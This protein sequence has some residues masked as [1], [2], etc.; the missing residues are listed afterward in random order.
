MSFGNAVKGAV[1]GGAVGA[2]YGVVPA[3]FTFGLSIPVCATANALR[4]GYN[5]AFETDANTPSASRQ[6]SP[7]G[8]SQTPTR[9]RS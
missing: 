3:L 1:Y 4:H 2:M 5:G 6:T 9:G 8:R 7:R